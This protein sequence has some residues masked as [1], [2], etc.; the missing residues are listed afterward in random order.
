MRSNDLREVIMRLRGVF[1]R[2]ECLF[3]LICVIMAGVS[4][5]LKAG[6][7]EEG[8]I[9]REG[10]TTVKIQD[11]GKVISLKKGDFLQIELETFGTAGYS[12]Q[13]DELDKEYLEIVS[14]ET[15]AL[16]DR[17]GAPALSVWRLKAKK[18]GSATIMMSNYRVWEGKGKSAKEFSLTVKIE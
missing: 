1:L 8:R 14:K 15:K 10:I 4:T 2:R 9:G 17:L 12:W 6:T 11:S 5:M 13:F 7:M 18:S 16:S 3:F